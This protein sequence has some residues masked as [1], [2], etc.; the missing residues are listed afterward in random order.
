MRTDEGFLVLQNQ[1]TRLTLDPRRGGAVRD[2]SWRGQDVLRPTP[3]SAGD[4]PF[5]MACFPMVPFANRV[6]RG[7]FRF[8]GHDVQL[9]RNWSEDPHP[10][11]GH[12]WR[13]PWSVR[14]ASAS[15]ATL[16]FE[17]G[18][19]EWPW[20]YR[21]EQ[22]FQLLQNGVGIELSI[23]NLSGEPMPAMLGL[24]PYF[25]DSHGARLEAK[26]P[27]VWLTD[28]E[29]LPLLES[30]T[31]SAWGFDPARAVEAVAL[32]N[33][34]CGWDGVASLRWPDR[35]VTIRATRCNFLHVYAPAGTDFF[36]IEPQSA[37]PGMLGRDGGGASIL[38]PG[39]RFAIRVHISAG[40]T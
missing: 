10:L 33:C 16:R 27:S 13:S 32:D 7:R 18:G 36:C 20:R 9:E 5:D 19:G 25:P 38:E 1:S 11:H 15:N 29:A 23:E 40:A 8:G 12:G 39:D 14:V 3:A 34:F 4:D 37:A 30:A 22:W 31:P 21:C 35:T 17:G 26:L 28:R 6:A 2:L 24:H